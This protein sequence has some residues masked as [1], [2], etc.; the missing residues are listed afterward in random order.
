MNKL[1]GV[2]N[3]DFDS[4]PILLQIWGVILFAGIFVGAF[5]LLVMLI[6]EGSAD[7][8]FFTTFFISAPLFL[9][10]GSLAVFIIEAALYI[11]GIAIYGWYIKTSSFIDFNKYS[12]SEDS[13]NMDFQ[14]FKNLYDLNPDRFEY[15]S[16]EG[17]WEYNV[18]WSEKEKI[19]NCCRVGNN[20]YSILSQHKNTLY[21]T[22]T[23]HEEFAKYYKWNKQR[24][25]QKAK[26]DA[27]EANA[28]RYKNNVKN[29]QIVLNQAQ[30][31]IDALKK[32]AD[33]E[34]AMAADISNQVKERIELTT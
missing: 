34:I 33:E 8:R 21:I 4:L 14:T 30:V 11:L 7:T 16:Y 25:K 23:D 19:N 31:D 5:G 9:G 29:M 12:H 3:Y 10:T 1:I 2:W 13:V 28:E 24:L 17:R 18:P 26:D 15:I 22:I 20:F 6:E 32:Q 27:I